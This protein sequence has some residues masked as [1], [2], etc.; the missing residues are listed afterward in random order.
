MRMTTP[1]AVALLAVACAPAKPATYAD[2]DQVTKAHEAWCGMLAD[3][4]GETLEGWQYASECLAD[5]PTAS[6]AYLTPLTKCYGK[7]MKELGDD[8]PDSAAVIEQCTL[9]IMAAANPGDVTGT[10]LFQ[11]RCERQLRCQQV[12]ADVC[13][14]AWNRL[15]P[16]AQALMTS[17][18]NL[19]AQANVASCLREAPCEEDPEADL[20]VCYRKAEGRRVWLTTF[21][22]NDP[23]LAPKVD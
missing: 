9:D 8:A 22:G 17:M 2:H 1:L 16:T 12:E 4:D 7:T 18:F 3:L 6:A 20:E 11:A 21:L 14:G 10:D 15:D 19:R 5:Y 13:L 23:G